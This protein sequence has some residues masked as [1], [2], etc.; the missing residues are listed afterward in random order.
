MSCLYSIKNFCS[1]IGYTILL[2]LARHSLILGLYNPS[3]TREPR[4]WYKMYR[5]EKQ[6]SYYLK[7]FKKKKLALYT[8]QK[9]LFK[10]SHPISITL[11]LT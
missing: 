5:V 7:K 2:K 9:I 3:M 1:K 8:F 11:S 4:F 10:N 6:G